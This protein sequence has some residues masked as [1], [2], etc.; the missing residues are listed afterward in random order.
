MKDS[1]LHAHISIE[2]LDTLVL[3]KTESNINKLIEVEGLGRQLKYLDG[4]PSRVSA[5]Q[6]S[7][8]LST[9]WPRRNPNLGT[10][11]MANGSMEPKMGSPAAVYGA[12][13]E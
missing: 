7:T 12:A 6:K 2:E 8:P 3:R 4:L 1:I 13:L 11:A 10:S 9:I 5:R